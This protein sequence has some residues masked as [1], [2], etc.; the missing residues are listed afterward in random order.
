VV[1]GYISA[2][3]MPPIGF[4]LALVIAFRETKK[5]AVPIFVVGVIACAMWALII[6]SGALTATDNSF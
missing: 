6:S 4:A 5:H 3:S 2:V 1:L